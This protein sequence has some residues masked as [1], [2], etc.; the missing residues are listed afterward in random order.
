MRVPHKER[1]Y[2][3]IVSAIIGVALI[4]TTLFFA[5]FSQD[6]S[7][8]NPDELLFAALVVSLF[9]PAV[10]NILDSRWRNSVDRRIPDFLSDIAEA[11][12]TGVTLTRSIELSAKRKYGPLSSEL[13]RIVSMIS[14]GKNLEEVFKEFAERVDTILARRTAILIV[15]TNRSGGEMKEILEELSRHISELTSI[16]N[17][18]K[19]MIRPYVGI[20]YIAFFIFVFI[21]ILLIRTF[22]AQM[23]EIQ[24]LAAE[25]GGTLLSAGAEL[26]QIQRVMF[27]LSLVE[28]F[29]AGLIAGKMGE[30]SMGAGLKHSLILIII[31]FLAFF[32]L[33]WHPIM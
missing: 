31:G 30:G 12:R 9:P 26:S 13:Q 5:F 22:F 15:E 24:T 17:E 18:R 21:T 7:I 32:L 14:W 10:V 33:V 3:S 25:A 28:G 1:M 20:M 29:F 23:Q 6:K 4:S 27:H 19:S 2:V 16:E 8:F 11:G